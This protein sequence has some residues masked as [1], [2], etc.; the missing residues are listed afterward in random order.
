MMN[1]AELIRKAM[2]RCGLSKNTVLDPFQTQDQMVNEFVDAMNS[3]VATLATDD[4]F[5]T[6]LKTCKF[7]TY[8]PWKSNVQM[9]AG[10]SVIAMYDGELTRFKAL[11]DGLTETQ[12][13]GDGVFSM[14]LNPAWTAG[15]SVTANMRVLS[16]KAEWR[17]LTAG[18]AGDIA[19]VVPDGTAGDIAP[20]TI[21][22]ND[23]N[24]TWVYVRQVLF[25]QNMGD[26]NFYPFA[27]ICPDFSYLSQN[28]MIDITQNRT[29]TYINDQIWQTKVATN[30]TDGYAHFYTMSRG[31]LSLYPSY[32]AGDKI[33]FKYYS[34]N[35][36]TDVN[37]I[38]KTQFTAASDTCLF[39]DWMIIFGTA[40]RWRQSKKLNAESER[41]DYEKQ[42]ERYIAQCQ[43][44]DA[45]HMDG[46]PSTDLR[47]VPVGGWAIGG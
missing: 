6:L 16:D 18:T 40:M 12:P 28:T 24:I 29:M 14:N 23:G 19:P 9:K 33:S 17:A 41:A 4:S 35:V 32:P 36:V 25:W 45:I 26:P 37:G 7:T 10:Q 1:A 43:T 3:L 30:V 34:E 47:S 5:S 2:G 8:G 20:N 27:E 11:N 38:E 42:V 31:G 13:A 22:F 15:M 44:G 46:I 21:Q 39:P